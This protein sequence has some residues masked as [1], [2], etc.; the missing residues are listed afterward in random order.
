MLLTEGCDARFDILPSC[1]F[2]R[3]PQATRHQTLKTERLH[4]QNTHLKHK[5][6]KQKL[7]T[8]WEQ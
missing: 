6:L 2:S 7:K 1:H 5:Q 4:S 3:K 8:P